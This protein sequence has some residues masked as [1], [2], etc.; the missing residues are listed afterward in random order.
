MRSCLHACIPADQP[1][2]DAG[3]PAADI[4]VGTYALDRVRLPLQKQLVPRN[5]H[6]CQFQRV[7]A[8]CSCAATLLRTPRSSVSF[9]LTGRADPFSCCVQSDLRRAWSDTTATQMPFEPCECD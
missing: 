6:F 4:Q 1:K 8:L 5:L 7:L 2:L 9:L 3:G